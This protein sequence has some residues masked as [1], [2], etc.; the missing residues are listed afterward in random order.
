M[1]QAITAD[2]LTYT[3]TQPWSHF[4]STLGDQ[5]YPAKDDMSYV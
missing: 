5:V 2:L 3:T 4:K 1:W